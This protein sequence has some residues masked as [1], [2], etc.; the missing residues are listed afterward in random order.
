V[1]ANEQVIGGRCERC[2][3]PVEQR[4]LEQWFFRISQYASRLL[5]NLDRLDWSESTKTAQRNWIGKSEGAE[6]EFPVEIVNEETDTIRVFT[7]RP[8]TIYG[9][10][11]L[12][13]AP[14]HPLVEK[15][16][17]SGQR[18]SVHEYLER[19][20]KQDLVT[21]KTSTEKTGVFTGSLALNPATE[22]FI[23]VWVADYVLMEY[24][25]GAIMAVPGHDDRDFEFAMVFNLPIVRV[26]VAEGDDPAS[27]FSSAYTGVE[28]SYLV[29]SGEF[30]GMSAEAGK[31]AIVD[32][33]AQKGYAKP[34]VNYRLHDW[35]ISRQRYFPLF[36]ATSAEWYRFPK[37]I[38]LSFFRTSRISSRMIPGYHRS[39][40]TKSG[41]ALRVLRAVQW[42]AGR[43]T[44]PTRFSIVR[45]T[46]CATRA[47]GTMTSRSIAI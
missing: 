31:K 19:T 13:L 11:Y 40:A 45:G 44:Y 9:A 37:R 21:R 26:V 28:N 32:K 34:V 30:D 7:T 15:L 18:Q 33:L 4:L 2:E 24:G 14:E 25:T 3:T 36:T 41:T 46:S 22:Q 10:T 29:N 42:H 5:D 27:D 39:R 1:L 16:T 35:C 43:R 23:E 6:I 38:C 17:T 8:D 20:A 12:V 47:S